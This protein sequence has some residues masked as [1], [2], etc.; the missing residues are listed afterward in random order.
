MMFL[1]PRERPIAQVS[2]GF[3]VTVCKTTLS[4]RVWKLVSLI[5]FQSFSLIKENFSFQF[6]R[7]LGISVTHMNLPLKPRKLSQGLGSI[8]NISSFFILVIVV[9]MDQWSVVLVVRLTKVGQPLC[10]RHIILR[11]LNFLLEGVEEPQ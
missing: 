1:R 2:N 7:V 10:A 4:H 9:T 5:L 6:W 3:P 8:I 11:N